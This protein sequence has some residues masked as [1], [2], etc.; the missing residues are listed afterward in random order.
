MLYSIFSPSS[1]FHWPQNTWP[2]MTLNGYFTLNSILCRYVYSSEDWLSELGYSVT[3]SK[4]RRT[5][6]PQRVQL[7]HRAG[8]LR[9][10]GFVVKIPSLTYSAI[11]LQWRCDYKN[12]TKLQTFSTLP[13]EILILSVQI[14]I[15]H[16]VIGRL[17]T[18]EWIAARSKT[19]GCKTPEWKTCHQNA[20]WKTR[21]FPVLRFPPPH[22]GATFSTPGFQ[23]TFSA[24][25][26]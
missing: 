23:P 14:L 7:L 26:R 1:P 16:S 10:H 17:K 20:G 24:P 4:C 22:S 6:E 19:Q 12:S 5:F 8:S 21:R 25:S 13:C 3:C 2:W 18:R 15:F 11:K 9:Q